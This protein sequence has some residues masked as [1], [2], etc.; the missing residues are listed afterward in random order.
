M[1]GPDPLVVFLMAR[2]AE[3]WGTARDREL[4]EGLD[5]SRATRDVDAKREMLT[6]YL[7]LSTDNYRGDG[8]AAFLYA[9][10]S[11]AAAY[12]DHPDYRPEWTPA[13][14]W[15]TPDLIEASSLGTPE[16]KAVRAAG[17]RLLRGEDA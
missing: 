4:A 17:H 1:T 16:A 6:A 15:P 10:Q 9:M 3:D 5:E 14:A 8:W 7:T 2:Y 12:S 11:Q 13:R